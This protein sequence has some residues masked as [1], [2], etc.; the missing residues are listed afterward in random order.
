MDGRFFVF[1]ASLGQV[2]EEYWVNHRSKYSLWG[3]DAGLDEESA[4]PLDQWPFR[5]THPPRL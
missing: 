4:I 2:P 5:V 1:F 3:D